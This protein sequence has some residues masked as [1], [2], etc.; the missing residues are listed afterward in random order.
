MTYGGLG[1]EV[2]DRK[3]FTAVGVHESLVPQVLFLVLDL[4]DMDQGGSTIRTGEILEGG[5][6]SVVLPSE[7]LLGL[8]DGGVQVEGRPRVRDLL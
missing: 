2:R 3:K 5:V 1:N 6:E 7:D 4:N 8:L